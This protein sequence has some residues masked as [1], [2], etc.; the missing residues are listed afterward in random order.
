MTSTVSPKAPVQN[1]APVS[2]LNAL[3]PRMTVTAD[4]PMPANTLM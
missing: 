1:G 4:Q 3:P 2:A